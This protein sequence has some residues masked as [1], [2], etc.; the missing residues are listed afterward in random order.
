MG[1]TVNRL[2]LRGAAT[3]FAMFSILSCSDSTAPDGVTTDDLSIDASRI[4]GS[5]SVSLASSNIGVGDTTRAT[6]AVYDRRGRPLDR[7]VNWRSSDSTI[8]TVTSSGL[9]TGI[10]AGSAEITA[11]R[12][13]HSGSATVSVTP[14]GTQGVTPVASV[15]VSLAAS[16]V[17]I[18]Q[19]TQATATTRDS[20]GNVLSGRTITWGSSDSSVAIVSSSGVVTGLK[21]GAANIIGTSEGKSGSAPLTVQ[22]TATPP[23]PPPPPP[24]PSSWNPNEPTS[25]TT[26]ADRAFNA[27]NESGWSD[28]HGGSG[29]GFAVAQDAAAPRS[30]SN[31]LRATYPAGYTSAGDGPGGSDFGLSSRPR[32]LYVSYF[33]KVSTNWYGH[34]SGVNKEFYAYANGVPNVYFNLR[35]TFNG[36]ITP[37]IALQDMASGGT[38]DISPNLVPGARITRGQWYHIEVVLVGNTA[39]AAD[40]TIDWWLDGTHIGSYKNLRFNSS[41]AT[42]NLFHYT[43]IWGGVGGP[44]VPATMY[45]D[46]DNVYI[47][48]KK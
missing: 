1:V 33:A 6:A 47:S 35:C 45:K 16:T 23:P 3:A 34:D 2:I 19:T 31:V 15:S 27:M 29:G 4:I 44:N 40:G 7:L 32:T 43:S 21:N 41:A 13:G 5:I 28:Q 36:P 30:P 14:L 10:A 38:Y 24:P 37:D 26:L 20:A 42:W 25:M 11:Y 46:W 8:A 18:G 12:N 39:G 22:D 9:V 48:G 17:S